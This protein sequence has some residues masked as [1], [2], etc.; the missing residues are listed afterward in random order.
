M[1][2]FCSLC[3]TR[4]DSIP[5]LSILDSGARSQKEFAYIGLVAGEHLNKI[6]RKTIQTRFLEPDL[7]GP[8]PI[9]AMIAAVGFCAQNSA[10]AA[11]LRCD[12]P[13][14]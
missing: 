14:C 4:F 2:A 9:P 7:M 1:T 3:G 13:V 5:D 11:Y 10:V 12:D 6:H 8:I